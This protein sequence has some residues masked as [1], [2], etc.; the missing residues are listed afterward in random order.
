MMRLALLVGDDL[1]GLRMTPASEQT[2]RP[3][4]PAVDECDALELACIAARCPTIVIM[5][6]VSYEAGRVARS[7]RGG[8]GVDGPATG[9]LRWVRHA[10]LG[11][12]LAGRTPRAGHGRPAPATSQRC[13][14]GHA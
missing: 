1:P 10:A 6:A 2:A 14:R 3:V 7:A 5:D 9:G 8:S 4:R 12:E 13:I 11:N